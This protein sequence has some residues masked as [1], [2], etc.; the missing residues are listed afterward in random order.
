MSASVLPDSASPPPAAGLPARPPGR[1]VQGGLRGAQDAAVAPARAI[2][3]L[4][5]T[6]APGTP[7]VARQLRLLI[8]AR[9]DALPWPASGHTLARWQALA[10]VAAHDLALA[11]LYEGHTDALAVLH[12]LQVAAPPAG[13][14]LGMWAAEPPDGRVTFQRLP[15]GEV[16]LAGTKRWCSGAA[17]V[18][19]GLLTAW[20][21]DAGAAEGEG[22]WLVLVDMQQPAVQ[23]QPGAWCAVGM[24]DS[25][26]LDVQL[27]GAI[28]RL[29]GN[30]GDYLQRPGF[31]Q[32]GIGVAACW[33][34]GCV[35]LGRALQRAVP[36]PGAAAGERGWLTQVALGRADVELQALAA[37]VRQ[38]AA[39]VDAHPQ[40]SAQA[41]ALQVRS[42]VDAAAQRLLVLTGRTLGATP[43]CRDPHFARLAADLPVFLRQTHADRDL[44][45]LARLIDTPQEADRWAL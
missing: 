29:C 36:A 35:A 9:L 15:D 33:Y 45:S 43:Y 37:L 24:A 40:H 25:Q 13:S 23:V 3:A 4:L 38:A 17:H 6:Q 8:A 20:P 31:W 22:P 2:E 1:A 30:A 5:S 14:C 18:S 42:A 12:E 44:A 41:L 32:G 26:S 39:W 7:S 21:A 10:A 11:K 28:A 16:R 34:G 27:D 19:H